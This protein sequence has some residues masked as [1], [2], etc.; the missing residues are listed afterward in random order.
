MLRFLASGFAAVLMS[1]QVL[2]Q[3]RQNVLLV[4][5]DDLKPAIGAFGDPHAVT[6]NID[7]L[8]ANGVRFDRAYAN[9][10]VCAPSR[11]NLMTGMRST[12]SGMYGLGDHLRKR[13]PDLETLPQRFR[14]AGFTAEAIGKV[15]HVGHG[16][17]GD[18]ES[19]SSPPWKESPID[20]ALIESTGGELTREEALFANWQEGDPWKQPRGAAWE[21]ADVEDDV[22][23]DGRIAREA[24]RRLSGYAASGEPF[25]LAVGFTKPH[26]P[27]CAP[28]KYWD[29]YD[30]GDLPLS[31]VRTPPVGA[32]SFAGK[33]RLGEVA[34]YEP[35]PKRYAE[36]TEEIERTLVHGYYASLS[37]MDAQLGLVL[38]EL[39]RSELA[40]NTVVVLWGDHGFHLG[41]LSY[42]T[43]HTNYEQA[44]RIPIVISG[45]GI[46]P[47]ASD[48]FIETVDLYPTLLDLASVRTDPAHALDGRSLVADL[49][50]D[51]S[52]DKGYAYHA[53][54]KGRWIG[55]AI[56]TERYRMVEWRDERGERDPVR[57][58][59]D[60]RSGDVETRNI[61]AEQPA[62]VEEHVALLE[63]ATQPPVTAGDAP[64]PLF[65]DPNYHGSCDPEIVW[66]ETTG[67]WLIFYTARRALAPHGQTPGGTPI[68]VAASQDWRSWRFLGYCA[69]DGRDNQPD[70]DRTYWAP[71][72]VQEGD[73]LH[74]YV[75]YKPQATGFWG[76]DGLG[77]RHF[78]ADATAPLV[79][80]SRGMS[81]NGTH[82]IDAG[83][84]KLDE[85]WL[86]YYRD[87]PATPGRTSFVAESDDLRQWTKLG[88]A[89]GDI[90]DMSVNGHKYHEAQYPFYWDG[91]YWLLTDPSG[92]GLS[93]FTSDDGV[94]WSFT[95]DFLLEPGDHP[96]DRNAGRHPS[97][98]V[99]DGRAFLFYHVE[100]DR[101]DG[102]YQNVPIDQ[103]RTFLQI[104]E[105]VWD[106][107][108]LRADRRFDL[109]TS[110]LVSAGPD[111][112]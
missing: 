76:G 71:A 91:Q 72:V 111:E 27:F 20:Y 85:R 8:A 42:W 19:W 102:P 45:P 110:D 30:P 63:R 86:M 25:F 23:A 70:S 29:L 37:Y 9:Q 15:F 28:K 104:A 93:A 95:N 35:V 64:L 48:S 59:Y 99:I 56:R 7:A 2:A 36:M 78:T 3:E 13:Y 103:R 88:E 82:A 109:P 58:L 96:S 62:V 24:V 33:N 31:S 69:F 4:L 108:T 38:D 53:Y 6:P 94:R 107:Q 47:S 65:A 77:I 83:V 41:D 49:S 74:M 40:E 39:E 106:G 98:A 1:G 68:G 43:K 112:R 66:N 105:L 79:W 51:S 73:V 75:T 89:A 14:R 84:L 44:A 34:A 12:T 100:P 101:P 90:T 16:N 32:P 67:E 17:P 55:H 81:I 11:Y 61:A 46:E 50:G 22:Y 10:A 18:A 92:P 80:T 87:K 21:R 54:K 52:S 26:L 57:E 60:Y 5:V 97:V